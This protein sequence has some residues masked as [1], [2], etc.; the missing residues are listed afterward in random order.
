MTV[1]HQ[2]VIP[3]DTVALICDY[4]R[5]ELD[6]RGYT[7]I[8]VGARVPD[9]RPTRFVRV[10]RTGGTKLNLVVD[11]AQLSV[12]TWGE[13]EA[14][15]HDLAQLCRGLIHAA[16][17]TELAGTQVYRIAEVAGPADLPDPLS[18]QPRFSATYLV[19]VRCTTTA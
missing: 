12:E 6:G 10:R 18:N 4:L 16:D 1:T 8:H 13:T 11:D 19:A 2:V 9:D 7:D 15:A 17:S 3:P 14:A 5:D